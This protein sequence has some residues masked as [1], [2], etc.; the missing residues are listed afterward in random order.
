MNMD[1][2]ELNPGGYVFI[3]HSHQDIKKVRQIRNAMEEEGYEPLCFYLKCLTDEDEIEGLIKREIDAREWFVYIDSPNSRASRW[4][5]KER[6]YIAS[7]SGKQIVTIDLEKEGSM[8]EVSRKLIRGLRVMIV[9]GTADQELANAFRDAFAGKDMQVILDA[10]DRPD[11][12]IRNA[13]AVAETGCVLVLLSDHGL[14]DRFLDRIVS[15]AAASGSI[16]IFVIAAGYEV[17][18][19]ENKLLQNCAGKY[20]LN[21]P[22]SDG[23]IAEIV[24]RVEADVTHDLRKAF[25]EAQSHSEVEAYYL[26]NQADPEAERLAREAQDRLDEEQRI[27][28]DILESIERG[29]MKMTEELRKYLEE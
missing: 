7:L 1:N 11:L 5:A 29:T 16:L 13:E 2:A 18:D 27:K 3:S 14:Q 23:Q 28:D 4:V 24:R 15:E 17:S 25:S 20:Y 19:H 10:C 6:E 9:Y 8:Q 12:E 21:N 22:L 26:K